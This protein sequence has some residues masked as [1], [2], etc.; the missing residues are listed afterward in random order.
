MAQ[1]VEKQDGNST[2]KNPSPGNSIPRRTHAHPKR[3]SPSPQL[4]IKD[5]TLRLM[6][7]TAIGVAVMYALLMLAV[8]YA[9]HDWNQKNQRAWTSYTPKS[10]APASNAEASAT[11][12]STSSAWKYELR[13]SATQRQMVRLASDRFV[14]NVWLVLARG[15]SDKTDTEIVI[16]CLRMAMAG[17]GEDAAMKNDLG[18]V[19][20][21]QKR[22]KEALAQFNA[23]EQIRPGFAPTRFNLALCAI[24]DRDPEK[25]ILLLGQYLGQR[26]DD[27]AALRLQST[28]LAQFGR[29]QDSLH[30]LEKFLKDQPADQPLFLEA[31]L[32]AARLGQTGNA[33][34]YLETA[35]NGNSIQT[36]V[37]AYQSATFRD[38]RLSG[39]GDKLAARMADKA[40]AAFSAPIP[41]DEI[42][43]LRATTPKAKVR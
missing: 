14:P 6:V 12:P 33:I 7:A 35:L 11:A 15:L 39:E 10:S 41:E 36:V 5:H 2:R 17:N 40:R 31:A 27:T 34:R 30:M 24:S 9:N 1:L 25:A 13:P 20:L 18:A 29:S 37:R 42:P 3:N 23:A 19:Y 26:P 8:K 22:T 43:P 4:T 32:L 38:I 16:S 21:Q 28:L